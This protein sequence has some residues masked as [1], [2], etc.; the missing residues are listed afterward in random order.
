M[1][2][3]IKEIIIKPEDAGKRLDSIIAN[4]MK[5]VSRSHV[6]KLFLKNCIKVNNEIC[7]SKKYKAMSGDIIE[8]SSPTPEPL[9]IRAENIPLD[10]IY[11]DD[12]LM[13]INKPVGMV[14]HPAPGNN[15]GT[16]VNAIMYHCGDTLS[17]ING[18]IRPGIVHRIDKDTSGLLIVAKNDKSHIFLSNLLSKHNITREYWA[19]VLGN[20]KKDEGTIDLPIGRDLKNRMKRAV[21]GSG[22][23]R[24]VTHYKVIERFGDYTLVSCC[25][26]TGRT[27]QI[28]VHMA[29]IKHPL[30]GDPLY[31]S[32]KQKF[33]TQGQLLHARKLGFIHPTTKK[34]MEFQVD[35]PT[36]FQRVLRILRGK[37]YNEI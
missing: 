35:P 17:S 3:N 36:E 26:E 5:D 30:L 27:H 2:D 25:L 22:E 10:I 4:T 14:V 33:K 15:Q 32:K 20:I 1:N 29:Y 6:Q 13:V 8:I 31:G 18:I 12:D 21:Y 37:K 34:Y 11:E 19:I 23:K 9:E 24:A 7:S 16:L 28:R